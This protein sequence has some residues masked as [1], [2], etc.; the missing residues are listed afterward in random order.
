M[1]SV[2]NPA[3]GSGRRILVLP[4]D[5]AD[6]A[7]LHLRRVREYVKPYD[8]TSVPSTTCTAE[9]LIRSVCGALKAKRPSRRDRLDPETIPLAQL[10]EFAASLNQRVGAVNRLVVLLGRDLCFPDLLAGLADLFSNV[11]FVALADESQVDALGEDVVA[12]HPEGEDEVLLSL[13]RLIA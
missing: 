8:Q 2:S 7:E 1:A 13:E 10:P 6:T 9:G 11:I 3:G 4:T 12:V 5:E